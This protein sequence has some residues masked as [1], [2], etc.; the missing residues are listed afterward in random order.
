VK[1]PAEEIAELQRL[2]TGLTDRVN[3][4]YRNLPVTAGT[5]ELIAK[6]LTRLLPHNKRG[7]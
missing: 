6:Y 4:K 5:M 7:R 3:G 2:I 1:P